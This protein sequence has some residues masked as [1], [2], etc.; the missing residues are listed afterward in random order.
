MAL[1]LLCTVSGEISYIYS[2][3][4]DRAEKLQSYKN[5]PVVVLNGDYYND[6]VLQWAFEFRDYDHVFLCRN[7]KI[8]DIAMAAEEG[9]LN[10]GFLLYIH[11]DTTGEQELFEEIGRWIEIEEYFILTDALDCRVFYCSVLQK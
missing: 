4:K 3:G 6:S 2:D 7:N 8:S 9:M 11:Q 10:D 1:V 5:L